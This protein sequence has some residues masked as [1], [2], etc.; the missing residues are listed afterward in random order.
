[1]KPNDLGL[2]D[3]LGNAWEWTQGAYI[4]YKIGK[5]DEASLD[6]EDANRDIKDTQ[7]RVLRGGAF[8]LQALNVR[9]ALR[10][11]VARPSYRPFPGGFRVARTYP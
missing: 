4:S 7:S 6:E 5:D 2:F 3:I 1:L 10:H 9:S 8:H 11:D